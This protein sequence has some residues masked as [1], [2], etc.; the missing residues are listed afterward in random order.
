[1]CTADPR[2]NT[3][4]KGL[5]MT[6]FASFVILAVVATASAETLETVEKALTEKFQEYTSLSADMKMT[7]QIAPGMS[8]DSTGTMEF[9]LH[10]GKEKFRNE[11]EVKMGHGTQSIETRM[12]HIYD[13]TNAYTISEVMGQKRVMRTKPSRMTGR[14]GGK[15]FFEDLKRDNVLKLLPDADVDGVTTYVIEA[16]PKQPH[17]QDPGRMNYYFDKTRGL[18][19]KMVGL[20]AGGD[21]VMSMT[22]SNIKI[23]PKLDPKRFEFKPEPG[24]NV[25]DMT[26]P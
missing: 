23:N 26:Q 25:I 5:S 15:A 17:P 9:M 24:T 8:M 12:V 18:I 7:M 21:T 16:T 22:L 10:D 11:L 19:I 14:A 13:G 1:M 2:Y 20:N 4:L 3:P 6:R